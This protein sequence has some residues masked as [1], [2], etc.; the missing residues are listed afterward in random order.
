MFKITE[1]PV[2]ILEVKKIMFEDNSQKKYGK[3][4]IAFNLVFFYRFKFLP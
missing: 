3:T 1:F 4:E 2:E